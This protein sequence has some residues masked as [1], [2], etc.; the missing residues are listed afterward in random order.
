MLRLKIV[1]QKQG[2]FWIDRET[3]QEI[4]AARAEIFE[5]SDMGLPER[6]EL[7]ADGNPTG[8]ILPAEYTIEIEDITAQVEQEHI[9]QEALTYLAST[10]WMVIRA[11]EDASKP[12]PSEVAEARQQARNRIVK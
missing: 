4:E 6:P 1:S 2:T 3:Q 11:Q 9:N 7:D 8:N 5:T 10:D 12:V